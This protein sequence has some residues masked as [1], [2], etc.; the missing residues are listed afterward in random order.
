M[1]GG[2]KPVTARWVRWVRNAIRGSVRV[3]RSRCAPST[4]PP[5]LPPHLRHRNRCPCGEC[6]VRQEFST[7]DEVSFPAKAALAVGRVVGGHRGGGGRAAVPLPQ[8]QAAN[9]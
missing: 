9:D 5:P 6:C 8:S 2:G 1:I 4:T 7:P 3:S